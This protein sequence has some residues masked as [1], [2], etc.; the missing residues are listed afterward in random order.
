MSPAH[1]VL[2]Q[3]AGLL[4]SW[5]LLNGTQAADAAASMIGLVAAVAVALAVAGGLCLLVQCSTRSTIAAALTS[6]NLFTK[7]LAKAIST[8]VND[9]RLDGQARV[10][11]TQ[12]REP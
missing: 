6:I 1:R 5:L 4:L 2:L 3:F 12:T 11:R 10:R 8:P 9:G 7:N